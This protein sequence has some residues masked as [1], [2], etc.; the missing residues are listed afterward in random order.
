M[1][2]TMSYITVLSTEKYLIGV[3][4]LN[5]SLKMVNSRY[6]L[7]VLVNENISEQTRK[8][9][10]ENNMEIIESKKFKLPMWIIEKNHTNSNWEYWSNTF[11]KLKIFELTQ[12]EKLVYLDSD[13]FVRN[14]IDDL[15]ERPHMSAVVDRH[16]GI[17]VKDYYQKLTSG[18]MVI[19]PESGALSKF[20][21]I[22][23]SDSIKQK[24]TNIGDQDVIQLYDTEWE[25]KKELHLPL[26]YNMFFIGVDYF[27]G[28]KIYTL[29]EISIVHFTKYN[30]PWNY[31]D[32]NI[33]TEYLKWIENELI[34]GYEKNRLQ[35]EKENIMF[36]SKN[37]IVIL[38]EYSKLLSESREI[39]NKYK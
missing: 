27:V 7:A 14:N 15:F 11:D 1:K 13:M 23:E 16:I 36:G 32:E 30:K 6:G 12:Y 18:V 9:I 37:K 19:V 10:S 17:E 25:N 22:M 8:I 20:Y 34:K 35:D 26:K 24:N 31:S 5:K 4:A 38:E 3:L 39:I 29:E 33:T 21:K 28:K 2:K